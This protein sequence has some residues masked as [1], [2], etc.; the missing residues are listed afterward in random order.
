LRFG[1]DFRLSQRQVG[2]PDHARK[3]LGLSDEL[4][5]RGDEGNAAEVRY[6]E[7]AR[8]IDRRFKPESEIH[9]PPEQIRIGRRE[10]A[11]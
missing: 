9:G 7:E 8:V 4:F 10:L 3:T 6:C 1:Y 2:K 5:I 11:V